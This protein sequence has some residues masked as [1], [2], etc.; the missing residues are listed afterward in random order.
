M[1]LL[2]RWRQA[3]DRERKWVIVHTQD[4]GLLLN[5]ETP[6]AATTADGHLHYDLYEDKN[7]V[8]K[9]DISFTG[10]LLAPMLVKNPKSPQMHANVDEFYVAKVRP[11]LKGLHVKGI[12]SYEHASQ[13]LSVDELKGDDNDAGI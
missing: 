6:P 4:N 8:R 9:V 11:W 5:P 10:L 7:G 3:M 12:D 1:G 2:E 13:Q